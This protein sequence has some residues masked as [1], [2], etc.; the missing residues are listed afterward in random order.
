M[1]TCQK[2]TTWPSEPRLLIS[3][4]DIIEF[5]NYVMQVEPRR[6]R[7]ARSSVYLS[8]EA[9]RP[10]WAANSDSSCP[11]RSEAVTSGMYMRYYPYEGS[12]FGIKSC[13]QCE[14]VSR[15]SLHRVSI[16]ICP[17]LLRTM[18]VPFLRESRL[19]LSFKLSVRSSHTDVG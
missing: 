10:S 8:S 19:L 2:F 16:H 18:S 15:E 6:H 17:V 4:L 14:L 11:R 9:P 12:Q 13:Q 5:Y 3:S 1:R 7:A